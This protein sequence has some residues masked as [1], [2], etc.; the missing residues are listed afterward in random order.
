MSPGSLDYRTDEAALQAEGKGR[1]RCSDRWLPE[2]ILKEGGTQGK[3]TV[4]EGRSARR[5]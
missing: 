5:L 1:N 4:D 3:K 2:T